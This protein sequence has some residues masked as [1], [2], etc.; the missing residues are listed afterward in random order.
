MK[1]IAEVPNSSCKITIFSWNNKY[2][3]KLEQASLE[4]TYKISEMDLTG[5]EDIKSI[6]QDPEFLAEAIHRFDEM[7]ATL[8][9]VMSKY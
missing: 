6:A 8:G 1:I 9:K 2:L 3:L 4:Q 5:D 7:R